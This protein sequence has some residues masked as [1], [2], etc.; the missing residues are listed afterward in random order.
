MNI[1]Q[2][3]IEAMEQRALE[4]AER[5]GEISLLAGQIQAARD[6]LAADLEVAG[7]GI[8]FDLYAAAEPRPG[9]WIAA[10]GATARAGQNVALRLAG[11]TLVRLRWWPAEGEV[12]E[13]W[14]PLSAPE[15]RLASAELALEAHFAAEGAARE[16]L[17]VLPQ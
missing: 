6:R 15:L 4:D 9:E 12:A 11:R 2:K 16:L 13:G 7:V 10:T 5:A 14:A 3:V 1:A 17:E 8:Y